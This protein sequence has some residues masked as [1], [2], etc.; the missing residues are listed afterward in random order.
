MCWKIWRSIWGEKTVSCFWQS[1]FYLCQSL[2]TQ[3][4]Q[5]FGPNSVWKKWHRIARKQQCSGTRIG[6]WIS[7]ERHWSDQQ[8]SSLGGL[9]GVQLLLSHTCEQGKNRRRVETH[10]SQPHRAPALTKGTLMS[11]L[12]CGEEQKMIPLQGKCGT[13][14]KF[15]AQCAFYRIY[16]GIGT[17][18][19][20]GSF[21]WFLSMLYLAKMLFS[22]KS[23]NGY[24]PLAACL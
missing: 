2:P 6:W 9:A 12:S 8:S 24:F 20:M 21:Q 11:L 4:D 14:C 5:I 18:E 17:R 3:T 15:I 19:L 22:K 7:L 23:W 13:K 16:W 10:L 1:N